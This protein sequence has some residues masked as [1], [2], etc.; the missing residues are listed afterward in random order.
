MAEPVATV[1]VPCRNEVSHIDAFVASL[2][3]QRLPDGGELEVVVADGRSDDGTRERLDALAARDPRLRVIDNPGRIVSTGLNRA[4]AAAR[5]PVVVRMDV[6]TTYAPD[7]VAQC[8]RALRETGATC[9]GGAW[10][11]TGEGWPQAAIAAAFASRFGSGG[12]ASRRVGYSGFVDTVYLGAW[13]R[14]ELAAL[15]GFDE[16]LVRNQDDELALRIHR[17]GGRVWQDAAIVSRYAPRASFAALFRQFWQ[18]GYWKVPVIR[19][20]RLP[21]SPRHLVPFGFVATLAGLA[22]AGLAW[23]PAWAALAGVAGLYAAAAWVNAAALR[24]GRSGRPSVPRTD[25]WRETAGVAWAF[26]CM[27]A[28]YGLGFG[29]ALW[30]FVLLRRGPRDAATTL[31]R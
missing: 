9:V 6:H 12:A 17:R 7:Y 1:V 10:V 25:G 30:D 3:A 27:H 20:H 22:L 16:A 14:D 28:G 13:R 29:R 18:Y 4:L 5:A 8:L 26:F 31:T 2:L 11:P 24:T 15:G 21:A 19:K 23:R